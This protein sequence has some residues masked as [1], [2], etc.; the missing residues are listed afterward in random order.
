[1]NDMRVLIVDDEA[2]ARKALRR[3]LSEFQGIRICGETDSVDGAVKLIRQTHVDAVYLDIELYGEKGFDLVHHLDDQTAVVF[4]T[5]FSQYAPLAFDMEVKDYLLKP[6]TKDRLAE[7]IRRLR[8]YQKLVKSS[9][10]TEQVKPEDS[11]FVQDGKKRLQFPLS[12]LSLIEADGDYTILKSTDGRSGIAWKSLRQWE[13]RLPVDQFV[14][15]HRSIIVN[16][17]QI[18]SFETIAGN[19]LKL[20]MKGVQIPCLASRRLTPGIRKLL[21]SL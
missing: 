12:Q 17:N 3:M 6:V 16:L 4:V 20:Y 5:A 11:I 2:M 9:S 7:N 15:I 19:R 13:Q 8:E 14:R 10:D 1:M 21:I 18:Q